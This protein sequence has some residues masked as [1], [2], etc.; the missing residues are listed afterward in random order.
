MST[1]IGDQVLGRPALDVIKVSVRLTVD[2]YRKIM[3][4]VGVYGMAAFI[5][6]AVDADLT[7]RERKR[8]K[9]GGDE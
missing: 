4:L 8:K 2:Q 6:A 9:E 1:Q 3:E 7:R 5:R